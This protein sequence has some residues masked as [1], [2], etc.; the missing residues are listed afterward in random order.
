MLSL[1]KASRETGVDP[2]A[3]LKGGKP[4]KRLRADALSEKEIGPERQTL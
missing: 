4:R 1:Q 3:S 2:V